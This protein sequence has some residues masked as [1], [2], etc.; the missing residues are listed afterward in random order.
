MHVNYLGALPVMTSDLSQY[1][2]K[3]QTLEHVSS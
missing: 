1:V 3:D 2:T